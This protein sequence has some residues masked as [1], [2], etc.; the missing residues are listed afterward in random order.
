MSNR[1]LEDYQEPDTESDAGVDY[2]T[3]NAERVEER[4]AKK[5]KFK[6]SEA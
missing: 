1:I 4:D 5:Q 6:E 3:E 2:Q